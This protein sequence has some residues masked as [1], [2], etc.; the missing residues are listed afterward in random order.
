MHCPVWTL[1]VVLA[2]LL[3]ASDSAANDG[4]SGDRTS[5]SSI[6]TIP[7]YGRRLDYLVV[8]TSAATKTPTPIMQTPVSVQVV[9]QQTLSD[10]QVT[11]LEQAVRNVSGIYSNNTYFGQFADDFSIRGFRSGE[12]VYR[13]GFRMDTLSGKY[14]LAN[15][16]RVEVVKGPASVLYGRMEPG[17]LV[18]YVTKQPLADPSYAVS[19]QVGSFASRRTTAD[20][21]GPLDA[22]GTVAYRLDAE[23]ENSG[24]FRQFVDSQR[25]LLAPTLR[26]RIDPQTVL[27]I[28]YEYFDN[29][30]TPDNIGLIAFGNRP[31]DLPAR[32]NL[33]E[34][35]DFMDADKNTFDATLSREWDDVWRS[36]LHVSYT[37]NHEKDGGAWGDNVDDT[38]ILADVLPRTAEGSQVGLAETIDQRA[39]TWTLDTTA[40]FEQ[41]GLRHTLL[42]GV[43]GHDI[44]TDT[45]CCGIHGWAL[46]DISISN[47]L[48][49][50]TVGPIE[51]VDYSSSNEET[52]HGYYVQDQVELPRHVFVLVGARYDSIGSHDKTSNVRESDDGTTPRVGVLWQPVPSVSLYST[53]SENFG[54]SNADL[55]D[56]NG[57]PLK[58]ET[59]A[60]V[61]VGAKFEANDRLM[62]TLS[63]YSLTKKDIATADLSTPDPYDSLAIGKARSRGVEVDVTG[64]LAPGWDVIVAYAYTQTKMLD[65]LAFVS[66]YGTNVKGN[67]MSNVPKNGG[68]VWTTY[69]FADGRIEGLT[70][71]GGVTAR[72]ARQ[73]DLGNDFVLPG[74]ATVDLMAAYA[75]PFGASHVTAQVNV[76]NVFDRDYYD[77]SADY[78]RARIMPGTPRAVVGQLRVEF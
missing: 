55:V 54:A 75:F 25:T 40:R 12:V 32:R 53:Y 68:R 11:R 63:L 2:W 64:E 49:R 14:D 24:S 19:Q 78:S 15:V 13:D 41:F 70:I 61:E 39:L 51:F 17:G 46:D 10:Q 8:D 47:P 66:L 44:D 38:W 65:D 18:N 42:V 23:Y 62:A 33:A 74:Y 30:T 45:V 5:N 16:E 4:D 35:T 21:T 60:Q 50:V 27:S 31:L 28:G 43:D 7:V 71:G 36:A 48:H 77:S 56:A 67:E 9:P 22:D 26:W 1:Y 58:P 6:E 69:S 52:W 76:D 3:A 72:G 73:G 29:R 20:L 34:P 37:N 57:R 59:A